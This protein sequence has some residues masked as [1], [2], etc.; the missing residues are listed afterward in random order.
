MTEAGLAQLQA[1]RLGADVAIQGLSAAITDN[2]GHDEAAKERIVEEHA[3]CFAACAYA[4]LTVRFAQSVMST[5]APLPTSIPTS[6]MTSSGSAG[7]MPEQVEVEDGWVDKRTMLSA[8][9]SAG[10]LECSHLQFAVCS[11]TA[12]VASMSIGYV[13]RGLPEPFN[14]GVAVA[15]SIMLNNSRSSFLTKNVA[16]IQ[17]VAIGLMVAQTT[18]AAM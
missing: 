3:L 16:R 9:H 5:L 15:C 12:L 10:I 7:E 1:A 6:S 18:H 13:G 14:V 2:F 8:F 11:W 17:G 4:R